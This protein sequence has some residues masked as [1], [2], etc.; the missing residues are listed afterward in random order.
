LIFVAFGSPAQELWL[1][2]HRGKF[3]GIV[4]M[5]VGQGFDVLSGQVKRAPLLLRKIGLEWLYRLITQPWRWRRQL[6][7]V[8]F[9]WL[10]FKEKLSNR[11][12]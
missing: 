1:Y 2:K 3:K 10:V 5:G 6:R 9:L 11:E 12:T 7:L 4:C 8:K